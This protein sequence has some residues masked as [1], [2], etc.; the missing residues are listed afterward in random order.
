[1]PAD[2]ESIDAGEHQVEQDEVG[3]Q[4]L[5]LAQPFLAVVGNDGLVALAVEIVRQN[6]GQAA[7]VLDQQDA[8]FCHRSIASV[9]TDSIAIA[10]GRWRTI[11]PSAKYTTSSAMLVAWSAMRSR[12][13]IAENSDIPASTAFGDNLH[14]LDQLVDDVAVMPIDFII[15]AATRR[16]S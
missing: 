14:A 4:H 16:A 9:L 13:R 1:M 10:R 5:G 7:F 3:E 2:F 12:W 15:E 6:V 11:S 8:W